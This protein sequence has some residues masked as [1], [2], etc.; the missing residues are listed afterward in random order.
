MSHTPKGPKG[1]PVAKPPRNPKQTMSDEVFREKLNAFDKAVFIN[2]LVKA[3]RWRE[4]FLDTM[5]FHK[6]MIERDVEIIQG[7][8][9]VI[10]R[11][12]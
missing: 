9:E 1:K 12:I 11:L 2:L 10:R 4:D 3:I 6:W 8:D 5:E 7:S